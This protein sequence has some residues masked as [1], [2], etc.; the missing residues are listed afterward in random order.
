MLDWFIQPGGV[1]VDTLV[2]VLAFVA[3]AGVSSWALYRPILTSRVEYGEAHPANVRRFL[4]WLFVTLSVAGIIF[5]LRV[6]LRPPAYWLLIGSV[7]VVGFVAL[8]TRKK[9]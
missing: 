1:P 6:H 5:F 7:V 9:V 3:F 2:F 4:W 8:F